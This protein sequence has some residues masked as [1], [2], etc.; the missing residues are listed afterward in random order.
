MKRLVQDWEFNVL[1]IY[2]YRQNGPLAGYFQFI[3]ENH[4]VIDGDICEVGVFRGKSLLATAMFLKELNSQKIVYG[5]DSFSGFP[6]EQ[7]PRD[8]VSVFDELFKNNRISQNHIENVQKNKMY[9]ELSHGSRVEAR[10][11]STSQSF[12][13]TSKEY[14]ERKIEFLGLDN[15]F[16]VQG[17]FAETMKKDANSV[18][19]DKLFC[20]LLDCDLY[21][22]YEVALPYMWQKLQHGGYLYLDEYFSLKFPGARLSI[23]QFFEKKADKP[24]MHRQKY[25][26]FERW[27]VRKIF[28]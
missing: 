12:A 1:D 7:D 25:G 14:V 11:I 18:G 24:Q 20:A 3:A 23:D 10:T 8:D 4:D 19:P 17:D 13:E 27:F 21:R 15:I 28:I 9:R 22:S 16:L 2:N 5:Y 26:D 6:D